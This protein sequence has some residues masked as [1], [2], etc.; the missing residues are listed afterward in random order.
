MS[1]SIWIFNQKV[2]FQADVPCLKEL[3]EEVDDKFVYRYNAV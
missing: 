1:I 2:S 3:L